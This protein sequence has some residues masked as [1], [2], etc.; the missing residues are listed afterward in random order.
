MRRFVS[1]K[2]HAREIVEAAS[3]KLAKHSKPMDIF[4]FSKQLEKRS[5]FVG[6]DTRPTSIV[7]K[8][9]TTCTG[10][11]IFQEYVAFER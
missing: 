5:H 4:C 10:G 11:E 7:S 9:E 3:V 2:N 8:A 1:E 6:A